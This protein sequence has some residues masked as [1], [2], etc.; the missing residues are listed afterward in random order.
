MI[1]LMLI[2]GAVLFIFLPGLVGGIA[3]ARKFRR[4]MR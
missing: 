3:L 4:W 1:E 2:G